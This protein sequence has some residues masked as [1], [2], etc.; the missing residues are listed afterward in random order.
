MQWVVDVGLAL[1]L[2]VALAVVFAI[3]RTNPR[4]DLTAQGPAA[5]EQVETPDESPAQPARTLRLGVTPRGQ[6][7]DDMARLLDRLGEG[8]KYE[9]F[10]LDDLRNL[11]RI[12]EYNVIFLT[13][14]GVPASWLRD[15]VGESKRQGMI[16]YTPN[17]EVIKQA[18]DNLRQ[19]VARGGTLYASDLHYPLV[20]EAFPDFALRDAPTG[21]KQDVDAQVIEPGLRELIGG[22]LS[23]SFDQEDWRP[24]AF[25]GEKVVVYVR[26][27]YEPFDGEPRESPFLVKFPYK[28]GTVIFT[29]FHN[30]RQNSE[31]E[32]KLLKYLVFS[33][34]T[35][36]VESKVRQS[37]V[38]GG[39]SPAKNNIF[40]TSVA[41]A[42]ARSVYH[43]AKEGDL[44]FVLGFENLGARL[45]LTVVGP[46][47]TK[48]EKEGTST[49]TIDVPSAEAGDWQYI[50]TAL[51]VPN[52]N[53]PFTVT[54]GEK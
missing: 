48:R 1:G 20:A 11:T 42:E 27:K 10:D 8:Y 13:C 18:A 39:F 15:V 21:K 31:T 35:A 28:D 53:F 2:I 23:L 51:K 25:E 33:A 32:L 52:D 38:R 29:S 36:D 4:E 22:K 3:D 17:R 49:F 34:V 6:T 16:E 50:V 30:E 41:A 24:A 43:A 46:D 37:M 14:S 44:Q 45:K 40:S 9:R 12:S 47:G 26:G 54:V 5:L 19:F 7:F